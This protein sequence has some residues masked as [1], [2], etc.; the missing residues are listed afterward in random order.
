MAD[1]ATKN[2]WLFLHRWFGILTAAFLFIA[3]IT[4]SV[5][6]FRASLDRWVNGDLFSYSGATEARLDPV[7]AVALY[8]A[9]NPG[10]Q[11]TVFPLNPPADENIVVGVTAKPGEPAIE[12]DEI[13]L[14]PSTGSVVG[15]R[16]TA[17]GFS[18]RQIIPLLLDLHYMLLAGDAGRLFMGFVAIGWFASGLIGLYLTLP[19]KAP[20]L[21]NWAPAWTYSPKRTFARQMLD[22]HRSSALWLFIFLT[23]LAFTSVT[24][25]FFAE[26]YEP[27]VTSISPLKRS[28]FH[29][30]APFPEGTVPTLT[31]A[32]AYSLAQQQA[33]ANA[34][35]WQPATLLYYPDWNLYGTT[36]SDNGILNY[37]Y[38]GPIYYYFD[39]ATG[40]FVHEV[41]PYTDSAGLVMIRMVYPL[42]SGEMG[43]PVT[44]FLIFLLGIATAGHCIT[45]IWL[46]L[47]KRGPR[48][49]AKRARQQSAPAE[50]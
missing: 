29:L 14:D 12:Q 15:A 42:H 22:L 49:A 9:A 28:L 11:V 8:E 18:G 38:L 27:V 13:F 3:A 16:S 44:V 17:A 26:A 30:D 47:K 19:R 20:F 34:I 32:E 35:T 33:A 36:F 37:K 4:G 2:S 31:Y 41:N 10:V 43:G 21:K 24:L 1:V 7:D 23:L 5:L 6:T 25:N 40:A 39:A 45:G 50:A 46:W 48:I